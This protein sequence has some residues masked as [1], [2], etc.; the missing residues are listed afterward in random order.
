M[1]KKS[2]EAK[3]ER[4]RVAIE[5]ALNH[6]EASKKLVKHGYDTKKLHEGKAL[7]GQINMLCHVHHDGQGEQKKA[8]ADFAQTR[9]EIDT[10]YRYHLNKDCAAK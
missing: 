9:Q 6:P 1:G 3:L 8:T 10:L 7:C 2:L 5:G 4:A